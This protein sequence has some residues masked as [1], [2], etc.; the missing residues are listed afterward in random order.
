LWGKVGFARSNTDVSIDDGVSPP[1][2]DSASD[3][4]VGFGV[5]FDWYAVRRLGFRVELE[6]FDFGAV[7]DIRYLSAGLIY[8]FGKH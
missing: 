4:G 8:R 1:F 5:G 2:N 7:T 6:S 3:T